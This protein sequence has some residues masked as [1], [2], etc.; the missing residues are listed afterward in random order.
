MNEKQKSSLAEIERAIGERSIGTDRQGNFASYSGVSRRA[1]EYLKAVASKFR[2]LAI[3][4]DDADLATYLTMIVGETVV[5][6]S[7]YVPQ[8]VDNVEDDATVEVRFIEP[9]GTSEAD[10]DAAFE[11][12]ASNCA[13]DVAQRTLCW[14]RGV[15]P[16][17]LA[18]ALRSIFPAQS[19]NDLV[20]ELVGAAPVAGVKTKHGIVYDAF[21]NVPGLDVLVIDFDSR[22]DDAPAFPERD[23]TLRKGDFW[24]QTPEGSS[25]YTA[26]LVA[27]TQE[28]S[29][30]EEG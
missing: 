11:A 5:A 6:C 19:C 20:G 2:E 22:E 25:E 17:E 30:E 23:G 7:V 12:A 4:D 27:V 16:A 13:V 18:K 21:S 28:P 26:Q 15:T 3:R 8:Y 14:L 9:S 1:A 24:W 29:E 10:L